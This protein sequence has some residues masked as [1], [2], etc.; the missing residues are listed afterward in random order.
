MTT[1]D[2]GSGIAEF[3]AMNVRKARTK[4]IPPDNEVE[5]A[6]CKNGSLRVDAV[7]LAGFVVASIG[8]PRNVDETG[9]DRGCQ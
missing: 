4:E 8:G 7:G 1:V 2:K 3:A 6:V 5:I 9:G